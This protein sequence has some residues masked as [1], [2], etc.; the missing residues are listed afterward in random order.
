VASETPIKGACFMNLEQKRKIW[1][2]AT[3]GPLILA[4][5]SLLCSVSGKGLATF[6]LSGIR[7]A[8]NQEM[9][10]QNHEPHRSNSATSE[11]NA[12][13]DA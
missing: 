1:A 12:P 2:Q 11:V 3:P 9:R 5:D 7:Q 10:S 8:E 13:F 6:H 4:S